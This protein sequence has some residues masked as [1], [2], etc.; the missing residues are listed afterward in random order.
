M[1]E[2]EKE[3]PIALKEVYK[4]YQEGDFREAKNLANRIASKNRQVGLP[5]VDEEI[6]V[7]FKKIKAKRSQTKNLLYA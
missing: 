2:Q 4:L 3:I 1:E 5:G 7:L 6:R